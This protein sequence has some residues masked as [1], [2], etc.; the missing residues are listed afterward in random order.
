MLIQAAAYSAWGENYCENLQS[1]DNKA[2]SMRFSGAPDGYKY[3][4]L[5]FFQY[6]FYM[7]TEQYLY[8]DNSNL[9]YDNFGR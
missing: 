3:D 4:T 5:N 2:S 6:G 9:N 1:F 7:G 8:A